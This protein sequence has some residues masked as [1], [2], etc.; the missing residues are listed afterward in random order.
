MAVTLHWIAETK[1][2]EL[3]LKAA[4]AGFRYVPDKHSGENIAH[5]LYSVLSDV[6]ALDRVSV[7]F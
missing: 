3:E 5:V 1:A 7:Q 6:G 2:G 4:L